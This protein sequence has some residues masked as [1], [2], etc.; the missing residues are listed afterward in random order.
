MVYNVYIEI[1]GVNEMAKKRTTITLSL[2]EGEEKLMK[3]LVERYKEIRGYDDL[4]ADLPDSVIL[5]SILKKIAIR[6]Q[7]GEDSIIS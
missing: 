3:E 1:K 6:L 2:N 7:D 4:I 5:K